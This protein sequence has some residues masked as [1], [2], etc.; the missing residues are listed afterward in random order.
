MDFLHQKLTK[1][2]LINFSQ[3]LALTRQ[4]ETALLCMETVEIHTYPFKN[5]RLGRI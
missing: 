2:I 1:R 3:L 4:L 5:M